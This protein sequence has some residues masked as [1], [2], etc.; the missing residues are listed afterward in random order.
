MSGFII[1]T[2]LS[3]RRREAGLTLSQTSPGFYVSGTSLL[4]T[5]WEK[6]KLL[7]MSNFSFSHSVFYMFEEL[8]SIFIKFEIV[9][10]K[11]FQFGRVYNLLFGKGLNQFTAA[12]P[13]FLPSVC[14]SI[15]NIFR[16]IFVSNH[17]SHPIETWY[18][19]SSR[20]SYTLL[21]EFR[22]ASH[23]LTVFRLGFFAPPGWLS[24]ERV[25]L[26][27]WWL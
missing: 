13:S 3:F 10:C 4:K 25:G 24:R 1:P 22:S 21:P 6:E 18:G 5:L 17:S 23:L 12:Y 16:H 7:V 26:M 15:T 9:V 27:T 11:L 2:P 8:F 20:G 19:S 14:P